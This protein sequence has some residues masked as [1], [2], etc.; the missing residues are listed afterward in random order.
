MITD[1]ISDMLTCIRNANAARKIKV[2]MPHSKMKGEI[3]RI[4][5]SEGYIQD[6][7]VARKEKKATLSIEL[8]VQGERPLKS[9]KKVSTPGLRSYVS[10][11]E[12]PR[13]IGGLG[14]CILSTSKGIMTGREAKKQNVGGELIAFVY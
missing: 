8:K 3:A 1:P 13:V 10:S 5:K 9:L 4:L 6:F 2:T 7:E 11:S 12:I 14:I